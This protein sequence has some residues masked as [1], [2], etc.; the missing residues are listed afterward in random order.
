MSAESLLEDVER[1]EAAAREAETR[2]NPHVT[3]DEEIFE[4]QYAGES[5]FVP[6]LAYR[7]CATED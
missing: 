6:Q 5:H 2:P 4:V 3:A 1:Y 7:A